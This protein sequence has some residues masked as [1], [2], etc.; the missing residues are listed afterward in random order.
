MRFPAPHAPQLKPIIVMP[1]HRFIFF[2][3]IGLFVL[4]AASSSIFA[5]EQPPGGST[6]SAIADEANVLPSA[7]VARLDQEIASLQQ[8]TGCQLRLITTTFVSGKSVND[9]AAEEARR[10]LQA[11][12]GILVAFDRATASL[13]LAPAPE[14]WDRYP[15]PGLVE[16]FRA[17]SAQ[18][19]ERPETPVD[20]RLAASVRGLIKRLQRMHRTTE[21]QNRLLVPGRERA[22]ALVFLAGLCLAA[23]AAFAGVMW[24]R[25]KEALMAVKIFFPPCEAPQRLGALYSGGTAAEIE[26]TRS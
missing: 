8:A 20:Q 7:E 26:F 17:A 19:R 18:M 24:M 3:M 5:A 6:A 11:G 23:A 10:R 12:P 9:H 1:L 2:R 14:L 22:L 15:A 4:A 21:K 16:A 25:R 13:A